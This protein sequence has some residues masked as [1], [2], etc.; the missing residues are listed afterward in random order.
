MLYDPRVNSSAQ[1]LQSTTQQ[2]E[3]EVR[4]GGRG[5]THRESEDAWLGEPAELIEDA[6]RPMAIRM[7]KAT[8]S[9]RALDAVLDLSTC[10][11]S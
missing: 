9:P 11:G 7:E 1:H 3:T 8:S 10:T 4:R 2:I 5:G 6:E